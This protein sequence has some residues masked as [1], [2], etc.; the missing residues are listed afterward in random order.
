MKPPKTLRARALDILSRQ[1]VSRVGLKRKLAPHAER[2]SK[3]RARKVLG[4]FMGIWKGRD[5]TTLNYI[6]RRPD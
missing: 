2:I 5:L 3:A 1:E 6:F 4:G